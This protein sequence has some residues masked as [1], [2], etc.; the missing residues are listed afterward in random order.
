MNVT[1]IADASYCPDT[2]VGGW[3]F[4]LA[5]RRMKD[6]RSG[7]FDSEL[8]DNNDAEM[9]AL[10]RGLQ[11]GLVHDAIH[12]GDDLLLQTDCQAAIQAFTGHRKLVKA[13]ELKTLEFFHAMV[14]TFQLS[15]TFKHVKGHSGRSDARHVTNAI[16]DR[17]ARKNMRVARKNFYIKRIKEGL[18]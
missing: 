6:G 2:K 15:V 10:C 17:L 8:V 13:N 18:K 11:W 16:C 3:A 1:L 7:K 9:Q 14:S 4:W 5:C 12:N